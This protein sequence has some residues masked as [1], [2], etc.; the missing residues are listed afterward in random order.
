V[1]AYREVHPKGERQ[2]TVISSRFFLTAAAALVL[3]AGSTAAGASAN[4]RLG[5]IYGLANANATSESFAGYQAE[6]SS[7]ASISASVRLRLSPLIC[8]TTGNAYVS[9][10]AFF[11][12]LA[13]AM[14]PWSAGVA[15][16]CMGG[17]GSYSLD[18]AGFARFTP[19]AGD[20]ITL[21][22]SASSTGSS[23]AITDVTQARSQ[24]VKAGFTS[25]P[26]VVQIGAMSLFFNGQL[27]VLNF[28]RFR[29]FG[30]TIDG[31]TPRAAGAVAVNMEYG[32]RL[33]VATS[34]LN[35]TGNAWTEVW[36]A[37]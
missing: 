25:V 33:E 37:S 2:A 11:N 9:I 26:S 19:N 15:A 6:L 18:L 12:T 34:A 5:E 21:R 29:I 4:P 30:A 35:T 32:G 14:P 31:V 10:G 17:V 27:P 3:V 36:K 16:H 28:G 24:S 8:P 23:A 22:V 13:F 20:L 7:P 1:D